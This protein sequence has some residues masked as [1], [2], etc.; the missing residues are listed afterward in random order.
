MP[1]M[2]TV[3][4]PAVVGDNLVGDGFE[5]PRDF[6][7]A[8]TIALVVFDIGQRAAMETWVPFIDRFARDGSV[9]GR[10]FPV[11][12]RSLRLMKSM[13]TSTMRKNAPS[14]EACEATIPLFVE[15]DAFCAALEIGERDNVHA[16]VIEADG[17]VSEH[18]RGPFTELARTAIEARLLPEPS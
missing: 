16:F 9:R 14:P 4:F 13:I 3:R 5:F 6:A 8:R 17:T 10:L 18:V 11:L 2:S 1:S 15:I 12:S 7:G